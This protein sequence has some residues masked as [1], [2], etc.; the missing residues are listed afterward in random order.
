MIGNDLEN[1]ALR[2]GVWL[3][4]MIGVEIDLKL[5]IRRVESN[6]EKNSGFWTIA[7]PDRE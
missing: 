7:L 1:Q 6:D 3:R 5:C 2:L 4:G